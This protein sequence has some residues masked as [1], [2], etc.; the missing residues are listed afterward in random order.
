MDA[1]RQPV[2]Y[3]K[4]HIISFRLWQFSDGVNGNDLPAAAWN[5]VWGKLPHLQC[6]KGLA[7]VAGVTPCH[8]AGYVARDA[9]PPVIVGDE[10]QH[11]PPPWVAG[12]HRVRVGMDNVVAEL[13][14]L[15]DIH[16]SPVHD[17]VSVS[18]PL[19]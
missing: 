11:L 1:L 15:W 6:Q 8:V 13:G 16:A 4:D 7:P 5:P 10:L 2:H 18:L 9:Q 3:H 14:V 17:Q 19:V 12:H